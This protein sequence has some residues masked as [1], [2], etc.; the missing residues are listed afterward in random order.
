MLFYKK[1]HNWRG[2]CRTTITPLHDIE[3]AGDGKKAQCNEDSFDL[4][5]GAKGSRNTTWMENTLPSCR[6]GQFQSPHQP[7]SLATASALK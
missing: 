2:P 6:A 3:A 7:S 5:D 1:S 4:P